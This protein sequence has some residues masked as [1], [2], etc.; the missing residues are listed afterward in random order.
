MGVSAV[1]VSSF[2]SLSTFKPV[3][4]VHVMAEQSRKWWLS[5]AR[6]C[7]LCVRVC[8]V[9]CARHLCM[10]QRAAFMRMCVLCV[11]VRIG[12]CFWLVGVR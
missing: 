6:A 10:R 11:V 12:L 5:R 2:G 3:R 7:A 9:W 1:K 8:V 4:R